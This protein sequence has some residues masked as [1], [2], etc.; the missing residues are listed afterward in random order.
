MK[1]L[2][3]VEHAELAQSNI[4]R[5]GSTLDPNEFFQSYK[6]LIYHQQQVTLFWRSQG[7]DSEVEELMESLIEEKEDYINEFFDRCHEAGVLLQLKEKIMLHVSDLTEWNIQYMEDL[8]N[9]NSCDEEY[10]DE[11]AIAKEVCLRV[12]KNLRIDMAFWNEMHLEFKCNL[13]TC[14]DQLQ[15]N[16]E[17]KNTSGVP[18]YCDGGGIEIKANVYNAEGDLLCIEDDYVDDDDLA[19]NRHASSFLLYIDDIQDAAYIEVYAYQQD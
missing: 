7:G 5:M 19:K 4:Q 14:Y 12:K 16:Y 18:W 10:I 1:K 15:L 8:L 13:V 9:D 3:A 2:S 11:E 6:N 17:I